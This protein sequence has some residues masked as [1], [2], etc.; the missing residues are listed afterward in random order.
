KQDDE[1]G[2]VLQEHRVWGGVRGDEAE[3]LEYGEARAAGDPFAQPQPVVPDR[4]GACVP[5]T[6]VE[7]ALERVPEHHRGLLVVGESVEAADRLV[8]AL[9]LDLGGAPAA[10]RLDA[11]VL[12]AIS[13]PA[14]V[15]AHAR[16]MP[17]Q[18]P[19]VAWDGDVG[20]GERRAEEPDT[21]LA[22]VGDVG[23]V[24]GLPKRELRPGGDA[25]AKVE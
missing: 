5:V 25:E 18:P 19:E 21:A 8:R 15:E 23:A 17:R 11:V 24:V 7:V 4:I 9:Q 10:G 14:R 13:H 1:L 2:G 22:A 12:A 20:R 3:L 16:M 6:A